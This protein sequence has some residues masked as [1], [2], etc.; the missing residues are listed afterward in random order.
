MTTLAIK[1]TVSAI[2]AIAFGVLATAAAAQG[3]TTQTQ[4]SAQ[5]DLQVAQGLTASASASAQP[6]GAQSA[7][8]IRDFRIVN[9]NNNAVIQAAWISLP[10]RRAPW[11]RID[12][13][14]PIG[15][16][17]TREI[18]MTGWRGAQCFF[19]VKVDFDDGTFA[20]W[21]NVNLCRVTNLAT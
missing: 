7:R 5:G 14:S 4:S 2:T 12:L 8:D 3:Y 20:R 6:Q 15:P 11:I 18:G 19:D 9:N 16:N 17:G 21:T 13:S 1:S 10:T